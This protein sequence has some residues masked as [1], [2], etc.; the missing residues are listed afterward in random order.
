MSIIDVY[1]LI[2]EIDDIDF[3]QDSQWAAHTKYCTPSEVIDYFYKD[4]TSEE[5]ARIDA[6]ETYGLGY[7]SSLPERPAIDVVPVTYS[8]DFGLL[9]IKAKDREE[10]LETFDERKVIT[11]LLNARVGL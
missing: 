6:G 3:I 8:S 9:A 7:K 4:L 2:S 10:D 1:N 5:V 11:D